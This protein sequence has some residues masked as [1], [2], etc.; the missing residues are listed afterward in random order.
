MVASSPPDWTLKAVRL[1]GVDV[2]DAGFEA[3]GNEDISG[4]EVEL[5]NRLTSVSG[6]V[7]NVRGES[8]TEYFAIVFSQQREKWGG[9]AGR[10]LRTG[11][12]DRDGRYTV[13]GLPAGDYFAIAVDA[14]DPAEAASA[15]FLE[16]ASS[17][18]ARFSLGDAETK[19]L[20]LKLTN[21][22]R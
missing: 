17:R 5:T 16:R 20:D 4:L 15:E 22:D 13:S 8:V 9:V 1:H 3:R 11:R 2:T 10:Y 21:I 7:T 6:L 14:I 12:P 19:S 18:A